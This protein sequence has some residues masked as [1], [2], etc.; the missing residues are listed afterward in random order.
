VFHS[1]S[2]LIYCKN[3]IFGLQKR[4]LKKLKKIVKGKVDSLVKL[5]QNDKVRM[6]LSLIYNYIYIRISHI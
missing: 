2:L 4:Q 6:H 1:T 3:I 5:Y